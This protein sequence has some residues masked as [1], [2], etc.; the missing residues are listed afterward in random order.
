[1][2]LKRPSESIASLNNF[3]LVQYYAE[4]KMAVDSS[5]GEENGL[6]HSILTSKDP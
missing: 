4:I 6:P 5:R 2:P 3:V 1:M